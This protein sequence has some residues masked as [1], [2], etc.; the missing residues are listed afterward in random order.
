MLIYA[1]AQDTQAG[2]LQTIPETPPS[3]VKVGQIILIILTVVKVALV[4][5]RAQNRTQV[6]T[7]TIPKIPPSEVKVC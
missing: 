3:E 7:T 4:Y 1:C 5:V 6:A 2:T